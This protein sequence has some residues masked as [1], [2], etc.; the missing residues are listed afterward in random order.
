MEE[1][2]I[3]PKVEKDKQEWLKKRAEELNY[4]KIR[5]EEWFK[6]EVKT[7]TKFQLLQN[8][9][10]SHYIIDFVYGEIAIEVDG[11]FHDSIEQKEKDKKKDLDLNN[12]GYTVIRVKAYD[13]S[14]FWDCI[15][16]LE[17]YDKIKHKLNKSKR[18]SKRV[19]HAENNGY[20]KENKPEFITG[21][22]LCTCC[23]RHA[24]E[25]N[26]KDKQKLCKSCFK[27]YQRKLAKTRK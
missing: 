21:L 7:W 1:F 13:Q 23:N 19:G 26:T 3:I 20:Y 25:F 22:K 4:Q 18:L 16:K 27:D 15:S 8:I 17:K 12:L 6:T 14:S 11:T 24:A 2:E 10:A 5:S 9:P